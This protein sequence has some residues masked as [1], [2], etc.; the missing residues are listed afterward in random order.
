MLFTPQNLYSR[1]PLGSYSLDHV[2]VE[3]RLFYQGNQVPPN[4]RQF[5]TELRTELDTFDQ[6]LNPDQDPDDV[7]AF[8]PSVQQA[9]IAAPT[10]FNADQPSTSAQAQTQAS[11]YRPTNYVP[12]M[13]R[14]LFSSQVPTPPVQ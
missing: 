6:A 5:R 10:T 14:T 4:F 9:P 8:E 2:L 11:T 12:P 7:F 13:P 3:H 1:N